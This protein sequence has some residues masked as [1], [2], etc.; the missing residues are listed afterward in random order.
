M[1]LGRGWQ[2]VKTLASDVYS[3]DLCLTQRIQYV[4]TFSLSKLWHTAQIFPGSKKH[5]RQLLTAMSWYIWRGAIFKVPL[6]PYNAWQKKEVW[7]DRCRSQMQCPLTR[8]WRQEERNGSLTAEWLNV[9]AL[10]SPRT[11]PPP[12]THEWSLGPWDIYATTFTKGRIW[13]HRGRPK[14]RE[15]LN[16]GCKTPYDLCLMRRTI[17]GRCA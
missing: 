7:L 6:Q 16:D 12:T 17:H 15:L 3:R 9:W 2:K 1:S 4:H 8:F 13:N 5:E 10:L 11:P 14:Q